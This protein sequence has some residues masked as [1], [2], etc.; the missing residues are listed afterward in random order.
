[1]QGSVDSLSLVHTYPGLR[2]EDLASLDFKKKRDSFGSWKWFDNGMVEIHEPQ[3]TFYRTWGGIYRLRVD[4]NIPKL[5]YGWNALLPNKK[6]LRDIFGLISNNVSQ[7]TMVDFNALTAETH[8]IHYAFNQQTKNEA[9]NGVIAHYKD[10]KV[11]RMKTNVIDGGTIYLQNKSR[12]IRIYNKEVQTVKVNPTPELIEQAKGICRFEYF[13]E[14]ITN[15]KRFSKRLGFKN[16]SGREMMS[17]RN[18]NTAV[19]EMKLLLGFDNLELPEQSNLLKIF[20]KTG[21]LKIAGD[22]FSFLE[23]QRYLGNEFYRNSKY[24][25]TK[26]TYY[27]RLRQCQKLGFAP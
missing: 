17:E 26:S 7:R 18:I 19:S 23:A 27:R 4:L 5:F 1:M 11:P 16:W 15:I 8:R 24:K 20:E 3:L 10:Y 2:P 13:V 21:D 9:A 6:D 25:F 12:G 14:G 22:I